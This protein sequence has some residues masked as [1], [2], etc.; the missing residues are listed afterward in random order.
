MAV[1]SHRELTCR[2][3]IES[4]NRPMSQDVTSAIRRAWARAYCSDS[5]SMFVLSEPSL[6]R[7][8][9]SVL[10]RTPALP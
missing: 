1:P 3:G 9:S 6:I 2:A 7:R 4:V 8:A 10:E 5:A